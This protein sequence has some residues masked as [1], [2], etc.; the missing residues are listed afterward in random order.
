MTPTCARAPRSVQPELPVYSAGH[1]VS[2]GESQ[3]Q[4]PA[5][6]GDHD[7]HESLPQPSGALLTLADA[8]AVV[9][10]PDRHQPV[11]APAPS[12]GI[13]FRTVMA[14]PDGGGG[15]VRAAGTAAQAASGSVAGELSAL[16]LLCLATAELQRLKEEDRRLGKQRDLLLKHFGKEEH[17]LLLDKH[18]L[19][20]GAP[21]PPLWAVYVCI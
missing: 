4:I 11:D 1:P 21:R 18:I 2:E 8:A 14:M 9:S 5:Q 7:G 13:A 19:W 16:E 10:A 20:T 6:A 17:A 12:H 15:A 3:P